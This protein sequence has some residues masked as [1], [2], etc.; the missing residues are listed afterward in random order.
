MILPDHQSCVWGERPHEK[1]LSF[2][3]IWHMT[4]L[5][6]SYLKIK[7]KIKKP[8][9]WTFS[10]ADGSELDPFERRSEKKDLVEPPDCLSHILKE[11]RRAQPQDA[12]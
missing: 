1:T 4:F 5:S 6:L 3:M 2:L 8:P 10:C 7:P 9:P 12:F 11:D